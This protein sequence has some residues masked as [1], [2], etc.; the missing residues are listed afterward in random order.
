MGVDYDTLKDMNPAII[1]C[2]LS[3][4]GQDGPYAGLPAFDLIFMAI[5]GLLGLTGEKGRP[6][7]VPGIYVADAGSGLLAAVGILTAVIARQNT[8]RGQ[9]VD[10]AMLDGVLSIL[11]TIS[12]FLRPS[13]EPAQAESL[14]RALAGYNVYQTQDGKYLALGIFRPQSWKTL[15]ETLGREDYI[16]HQ[17]TPGEKQDEIRASL[18]DAFLTRTRDEWCH[19]LRKLDVEVGPVH[20]LPEVYTDDHILHRRMVADVDHPTAGR[21]QQVGIPI[22]LSETPGRIRNPAPA[23][24]QDTEAVLKELDYDEEAIEALRSANAI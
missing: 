18:Q 1:Y 22:K 10:I 19:L 5:G 8:G 4:F 7:P 15:C 17:W 13:G 11:T 14:G 20:S 16:D 24:G 12:G 6:P 2:S 3:G 23:I 9:F 21:M